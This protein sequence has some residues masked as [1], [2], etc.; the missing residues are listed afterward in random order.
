M[1]D[2]VKDFSGVRALDHVS[3]E[4]RAGEV[5]VLL[6]EN[7]AGKSTLIKILG[8]VVAPTSGVLTVHGK[9]YT[10]LTPARA[11]E[12]GI[13]IIHQEL[14][15]VPTLSVAENVFLGRLPTRRAAGF[16]WVDY[17]TLYRRTEQE[18][19]RFRLDVDPHTPVHKLGLAMQQMVEIVKALS[20]GARIVVMDEPTSALT[21]REAGELFEV[22]ARLKRESV[23]IIY[24][25]HRL[26]E[27]KTIG[28]RVTVL[29][30]GTVVGTRD[31]KDV[32]E[33]ELV[34]MMVGRKIVR[35]RQVRQGRRGSEVLRVEN[36]TAPGV[37]DVSFS[38]HAGEIV[39]MAGIV[40]AGRTEIARA[41]VGDL[42][43]R[44]GQVFIDG[45]P[46]SIHSPLDA[47]RCGIGLIP[48]SRREQGLVL[49]FSVSQNLTLP[50]LQLGAGLVSRTG[51]TLRSAERRLAE[52]TAAHL[53]IKSGSV[54]ERVDRLSGG[55]QQKVVIGKW[56][57]LNTKVL[58]FDEPTRGVDI[59]AKAEIHRII[60]DLAGQGRAILLI[61]SEMPELLSVCDRILVV[62]EG[63][64]TGE[65][66]GQA[67]EEELV[68]ACV[69][70][71]RRDQEG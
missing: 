46:V 28:D 53:A 18:L 48:E 57:F 27:V 41:I 66:P 1:Q 69:T 61:S 21:D 59:G 44:R 11:R 6:G 32:D 15:L 60:M 71:R 2:I 25:S 13:G 55:N 10:A 9:T 36:L 30:D 67:S 22:I 64:I 3:F 20:L 47:L 38:V 12:L 54:Q 56:L 4:L 16:S 37:C 43:P 51:F 68:Y 45:V 19:R 39:G 42:G 52:S 50:A 29:K 33:D 24:I 17:S 7:G 34:Q 65:F 23:S 14:S 8:G 31:V 5:H 49:Q 35:T 63:R 62:Y 26:R 58:I 70:G 40:G